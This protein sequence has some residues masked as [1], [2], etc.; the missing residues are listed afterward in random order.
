LGFTS[1]LFLEELPM[2]M[3][4]LFQRWRGFTLIELLVVIAIIAILIGLLV[5]AVQKVRDAAARTQCVNNLHQIGIACHMANDNFKGMPRYAELGYPT[6]GA[7]APPNPRTFDG[8]VHFYLLPFLEQGNLMQLWNG[9]SNNGSNGLNGPNIPHTP[10]VFVCPSDPTMTDDRTTNGKPALASGT[11]YAI[12]SYSFNGQVFGNTCQRPR[13]PQTFRDGTSNT[14][15]VFERYAICGQNGEVRTWGDGAGNSPNAEVAYLVAPGDNPNTPG[16]AWVNQF[17]TNVFQSNP[18]PAGCLAS[19]WNS[20][21]PHHAMSVLLA[22]A[23]TRNV[24]PGVSLATWRALITPAGS[25]FVGS[26]LD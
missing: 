4:R 19:R 10:E 23:S 1:V 3:I 24:S 14:A 11:G 20:A 6:A 2:P 15:L 22:D 5:P 7:F 12:T 21:T 25:D 9:V 13:I 8:T 18:S 16:V 17:V 26:D